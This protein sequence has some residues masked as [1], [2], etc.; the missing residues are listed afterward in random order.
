M[1]DRAI[2]ELFWQRDEAAIAEADRKHGRYCFAIARSILGSSEDAE[3]S[4][5]DTYANAWNSM[6]PH[7]PENLR[8]FLAKLTR[9]VS[10][11]R[12]RSRQTQKR[13]GGEAALAYE[14]LSDCI[15]GGD[16]PVQK[17][18]EKELAA[19]I[20]RFLESLPR[21]SRKVFV[22][23]YWYFESIAEIALRFGFSQSKVKS[24]LF[25]VR[26]GLKKALEKEGM[27]C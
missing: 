8:T 13:G 18:E 17:L 1:E 2:V 5:N 6:P 23:R 9:Y 11:K 25:R 3:E 4:L 7:R 16:C 19:V 14:E 21:Q 10:L 20:D 15:P 12:W 24:I 22:C 26:G 27:I